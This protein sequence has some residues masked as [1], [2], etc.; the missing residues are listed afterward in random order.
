MIYMFKLG[1]NM[2]DKTICFVKGAVN[3]SKSDGSRNFVLVPRI[4]RIRQNEVGIK[5]MD[6]GA[7]KV[8]NTWRIS[9]HFKVWFVTFIT[10][11]NSPSSY[12]NYFKTFDSLVYKNIIVCYKEQ[13]QHIMK[14]NF[15]HK[16]FHT[17][18]Q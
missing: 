9:L 4:F 13:Q 18:V 6:S 2:A 14:L 10:L 8:S 12:E 1:H 16:D 5:T 7:L 15:T 3:Y 17:N 11:T